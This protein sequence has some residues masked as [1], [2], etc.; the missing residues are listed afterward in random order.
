MVEQLA[1]AKA[2]EAPPYLQAAARGAYEMRWW[3]LLSCAQQNALAATLVDDS[4]LLL[5]GRDAPAPELA[6]ILIDDLH[7]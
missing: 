1:I 7:S 3:A 5:D 2:R 4:V 6:E